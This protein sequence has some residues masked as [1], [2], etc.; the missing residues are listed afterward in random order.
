M[1]VARPRYVGQLAKL[2][3]MSAGRTEGGDESLPAALW[4]RL[5]T[6]GGLAIRLP[7]HGAIFEGAAGVTPPGDAQRARQ[8]LRAAAEYI[9]V[10]EAPPLPWRGCHRRNPNLASHQGEEFCCSQWWGRRLNRS[11]P[12]PRGEHPPHHTAARPATTLL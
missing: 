6:C 3:P 7:G 9:S 10:R 2:F 4:G 1:K 12:R 8:R 5:A 11:D